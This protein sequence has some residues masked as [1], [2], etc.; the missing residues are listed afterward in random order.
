MGNVFSMSDPSALL[1]RGAWCSAEEILERAQLGDIIEFQ[2]C[3][4]GHFAVYVGDGCVINYSRKTP[5]VNLIRKQKLLEV[6]LGDLCRVNNLE[7]AVQ[8][9]EPFTSQEIVRRAESRLGQS[10]PEEDCEC[11]ATWCRYGQTFSCQ[12]PQWTPAPPGVYRL[13]ADWHNEA[14]NCVY[15][16]WNDS[17]M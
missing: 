8:F 12:P 10:L 14:P 11:F 5:A 7:Q 16:P 6:S 4:Y 17:V 9:Q 13:C 3:G 1:Q 15:D 2:R